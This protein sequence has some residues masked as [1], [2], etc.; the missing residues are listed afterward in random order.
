MAA[1]RELELFLKRIAESDTEALHVVVMD[2]AGF[3]IKQDDGQVPT[4]IR[5]L[6]LPPY[7]PELNP[8]EWFGRVVKAPM[9]NR[10][11]QTLQKLEDHLIA[12][13]RRWSEPSY[14][15][16]LIQEWT[17]VQVN[18]ITKTKVYFRVVVGITEPDSP[19]NQGGSFYV[20]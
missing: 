1:R 20:V 9:T 3:H 11:Y 13:A 15:E 17:K 7:C 5:V 4:N 8:A 12:V 14:A 16:S 2:Q 10:I 6:P 19:V 18:A